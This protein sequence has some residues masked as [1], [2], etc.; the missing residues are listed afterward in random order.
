M[1]DC[2]DPRLRQVSTGRTGSGDGPARNAALAA[3]RG[4]FIANLDADDAMRPER[5]AF[6]LPYRGAPW[7]GGG[8]YGALD[9]RSPD[10]DG[11]PAGSGRLPADGRG[12]PRPP[13]AD[14]RAPPPRVRRRGLARLR[15]LQRCRVQ[16]RSVEPLPGIP[17]PR[18]DRLRLCQARRLDHPVARH[19]RPGGARLCRNH[20][21]HRRGPA[22]TSRPK[23]RRRPVR[24]SPPMPAPTRRSGRPGAPAKSRT[25]KPGWRHDGG[26]GD[27]RGAADRPP[28]G[29]RL[30]AGGL[31]RR[32]PLQR[33]AAGG[34]DACGADRASGPASGRPFRMECR[35][36]P[37]RR[38]RGRARAGG[39]AHQLRVHLRV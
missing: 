39:R 30:R 38:L 20:R 18:P 27:G 21:R 29:A 37:D 10:E 23:S 22:S 33:L 6:M 2:A 17:R 1:L 15:L 28:S 7:R 25:W 8:Q 36:G 3:A 16:P 24:S 14:E 35:R 13:P 11:V 34:G 26:A 4:R 9:R 31:L 12:D 19:G 5:L 32:H